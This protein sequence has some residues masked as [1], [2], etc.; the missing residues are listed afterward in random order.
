MRIPDFGCHSTLLVERA[1]KERKGKK[2]RKKGEGGRGR[3]K[4]GP[5]T[6]PLN[7]N[8]IHLQVK[9]KNRKKKKEKKAGVRPVPGKSEKR[10]APNRYSLQGRD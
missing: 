6:V 1:K 10:Y 2:G 4:K 3:R 5:K 9:E 8:L 7:S